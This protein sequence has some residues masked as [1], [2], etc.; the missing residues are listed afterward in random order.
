MK[1]FI[2]TAIPY[3]NAKPHIGFAFEL[4]QTDVLARYLRMAGNDVFFLTGSDENSLKNVLSAKKE[5]ISTEEL[6]RRN[7]E[8]FRDLTMQL[9]I[10]NNDFI[11]TSVEERHAL[12]A[13]KLW[14]ACFDKGDIYQKEYEGLYC[15]GCEDFY[16][17]KDLT[18]DGLCPEHRTKPEIVKEKNYFF[19]LSNYG[20]LLLD[21]VKKDEIKIIPETRKNE[22]V[23]F[24]KEGLEDF[25]ISR[26]V[27]R[28]ENWGVKVPDDDLQIMYVW[29]D[30]L[31][32][33]IT[34]L[35]YSNY[36]K[37]FTEYWQNGRRIHDIGKG[38][39]RFHAIYWPAMLLSAGVKPP[40]EIFVHGYLTVNGQKMSK[41]LG[42]VVDP[43]EM[44]KKYGDDA[45]RY[46]LMSGIT[47]FEDGDFSEEKLK[48][49]Y[50][51]LANNLGNLIMRI[52]KIAEK[53]N[54]IKLPLPQLDHAG[55]QE[56]K[57]VIF[58]RGWIKKTK[59][60]FFDRFEKTRRLDAMIKTVENDL[61][62]VANVYVDQ[63]EP[64]KK[65][66][67]EKKEIIT[68]MAWSVIWSAGLLMP[69]IPE[70]SEK[71][72]EMLG[73][74]PPETFSDLEKITEINFDFDKIKPLFPRLEP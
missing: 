38:I 73:I 39:L 69:F 47:P 72:F 32:N 42:N 13:K 12:G 45:L 15:V 40:S 44:I 60:Q 46:F 8:I 17:E 59:E 53:D 9:N 29:F 49:A 62:K 54:L 33:Y 20:N 14:R 5:G 37:K 3:V 28:A 22:V 2:S 1:I 63:K 52:A 41:S 18:Q 64:W 34:A 66:P 58:W 30:A 50:S 27:E 24:I 43:V 23:S 31:S 26:S 6:V 36:G 21:M 67:E 7:A 70:T 4:V 19:K 55:E 35:D 11:R 51:E 25:S 56:T 68:L 48:G 16:K 10:S 71:I 74:K 57:E 65:N 61:L